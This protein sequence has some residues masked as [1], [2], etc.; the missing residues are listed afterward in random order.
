MIFLRRYNRRVIVEG[1]HYNIHQENN[2]PMIVLVYYEE[3][4]LVEANFGISNADWFFISDV[5]L[6]KS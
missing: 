6:V 4:E 5:R 1:I 2:G 3:E